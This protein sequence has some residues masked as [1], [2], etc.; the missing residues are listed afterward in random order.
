MHA[1]AYL[2]LNECCVEVLRVEQ[3]DLD[4][5]RLLLDDSFQ[6]ILLLIILVCILSFIDGDLRGVRLCD[7]LSKCFAARYCYLNLP[8]LNLVFED[9]VDHLRCGQGLDF[10]RLV[11]ACVYFTSL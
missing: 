3:L 1:L 11:F 2:E 10:F 8:R 6:L 5:G 4:V 7:T 9:S